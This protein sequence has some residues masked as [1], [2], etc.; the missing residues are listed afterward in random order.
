MSYKISYLVPRKEF[1]RLI[2][3]KHS[4]AVSEKSS[5][6]HKKSPKKPSSPKRH[7]KPKVAAESS[8]RQKVKKHSDT[9]EK[10]VRHSKP[11]SQKQTEKNARHPKSSGERTRKRSSVKKKDRVLE[12]QDPWAW[13]KNETNTEIQQWGDS[14]P[15]LKKIKTPNAEKYFEDSPRKKNKS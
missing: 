11:K 14:E 7:V 1:E 15:P 12:E 4:Q 8:H 5:D 6:T 3:E 10:K 13:R 2:G 9:T